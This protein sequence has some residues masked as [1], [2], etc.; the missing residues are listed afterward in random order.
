MLIYNALRLAV[1]SYR[2]FSFNRGKLEQ[3]HHPIMSVF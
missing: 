3:K 1:L 2:P